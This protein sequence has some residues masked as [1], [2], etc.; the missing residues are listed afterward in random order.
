MVLLILR[1]SRL[2]AGL[3]DQIQIVVFF[4]IGLKKFKFGL[5]VLDRGRM[6]AFLLEDWDCSADFGMA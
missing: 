3:R 1:K 4:E 6:W 5:I 2:L